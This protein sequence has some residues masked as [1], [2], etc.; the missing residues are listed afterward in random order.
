MKNSAEFDNAFREKL[1]QHAEAPPPGMWDAISASLPPARRKRR[2]GAFWI[3]FSGLAL[4]SCL[5]LGYWI[6][7]ARADQSFP[8]DS[9]QLHSHSI[10]AI[11]TLGPAIIASGPTHKAQINPINQNILSTLPEPVLLVSNTATQNETEP[12]N[13]SAAGQSVIEK[14]GGIPTNQP[15]PLVAVETNPAIEPLKA[16]MQNALPIQVP[17]LQ[18]SDSSLSPD[19]SLID[20]AVAARSFRRINRPDILLGA[21][22]LPEFGNHN[23]QSS[24][25]SFWSQGGGIRLGLEY[26]HLSIESGLAFSLS[27]DTWNYSLDYLSRDSVGWYWDVVAV[28]FIP[29]T[30]L[31]GDTIGWEPQ[32]NC[33]QANYYDSVQ[34]S[35]SETVRG[36]YSYLQVP[37]LLG[38]KGS[39][40]SMSR[41]EYA[42]KAGLIYSRVITSDAPQSAFNN[43]GVRILQIDDDSYLRRHDNL[44]WVAAAELRYGLGSRLSVFAEPMLRYY[45]SPIYLGENQAELSRPVSFSLRGGLL[46]KF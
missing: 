44:Q 27:N 12:A 30:N 28:S 45:K 15:E 5:S 25:G 9:A 10:S 43:S 40:S 11:Q 41:W 18:E 39:F 37:F 17:P 3:G 8:I 2:W 31:Q 35:Y 38:Y 21:Y 24:L 19:T 1:G 13:L 29:L 20:P 7:T 32:Y 34:H 6:Y 26:R 22:Y 4:L 14:G 16:S 23:Q 46:W 33:V 42:L 36:T